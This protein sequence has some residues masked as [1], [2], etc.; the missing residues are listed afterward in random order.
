[1]WYA[2]DYVRYGARREEHPRLFE[3][4]RSE[5]AMDQ[6]ASSPRSASCDSRIYLVGFEPS[7]LAVGDVRVASPSFAVGPTGSGDLIDRSLRQSGHS[8]GHSAWHDASDQDRTRWTH[9]PT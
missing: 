6:V 3:W 5:E 4:E 2:I 8:L 1:M 9:Q 7:I